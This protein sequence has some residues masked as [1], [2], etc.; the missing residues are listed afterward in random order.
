M[1]TVEYPLLSF[2]CEFDDLTA[3]DVEEKGF[4]DHAIVTSEDG[5]RYQLHFYDPERLAVD[6]KTDLR[7]GKAC[8]GEPG[9]VIVP[10]VTPQN[11]REA[12]KQ[13]VK[14]GYFASL[15]PLNE[16]T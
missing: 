7:F 15:K 5:S 13:L 10:R 14:D 16:H 9:L 3:I 6:L 1:G 4:F 12:A 11:M 8:I 2:A